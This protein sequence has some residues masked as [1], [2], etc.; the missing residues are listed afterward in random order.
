[1]SI[2]AFRMHEQETSMQLVNIFEGVY[3]I[4]LSICFIRPI[5]IGVFPLTC[6][7]KLGSVGQ[8]IFLFFYKFLFNK[9]R[10]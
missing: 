9:I 5:K 1:M 2:Y 10:S 3:S 7:I 4:I 8:K 6:Q